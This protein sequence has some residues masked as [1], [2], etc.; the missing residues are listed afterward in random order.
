MKSKWMEMSTINK[1]VLV[2][3]IV[4]SIVII[5]LALLQIWGVM[6]S[7]INYTMPLL[8]VYFVILS[9]QEWKTQRGYAL[10]SIGVA[11]F[12]FIVAF[13]VWFGK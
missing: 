2:V 5:V 11:L 4:L 7:A 13:V 3:R 12:I 1:V 6:K 10:F 8:G 9:I